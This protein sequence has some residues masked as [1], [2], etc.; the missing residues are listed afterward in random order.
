MKIK[1]QQHI[2]KEFDSVLRKNI[3][4]MLINV[5]TRYGAK[6]GFT[7]TDLIDEFLPENEILIKIKKKIPI[8]T[9]TQTAHIQAKTKT[10]AKAKAKA[11]THTKTL[12][13]A[14]TWSEG[15]GCQCTRFT[16]NNKTTYCRTHQNQIRAKGFL[17]QGTIHDK[18]NKVA[19][20]YKAKVE[21]IN[22]RTNK[23]K[24][25]TQK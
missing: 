9:K 20:I 1:L 7:S 19:I 4:E 24:Q 21:R 18:D 25:K 17:W 12:C 11:K 6:C 13:I 14:R 5:A 16:P 3:T 15:K 23:Q 22:K 2:F 8:K 10:K